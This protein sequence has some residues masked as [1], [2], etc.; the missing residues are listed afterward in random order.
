MNRVKWNY[1]KCKL[2][3]LKY[4]DR[5]S[6]NQKSARAYRVAKINNWLEDFCKHM[7]ARKHKNGYWTKEKCQEEALKYKYRIDFQKYSQSAYVTAI[8]NK[9]LQDICKHMIKPV[10]NKFKWT[11]EKCEELISL[12]QYKNKRAFQLD[13]KSAYKS[14]LRNGWLNDLFPKLN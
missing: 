9:W 11:K 3:A 7:K 2:E 6:F 12:K 10:S 14:A 4:K 13:N 1:E 5:T 8:N